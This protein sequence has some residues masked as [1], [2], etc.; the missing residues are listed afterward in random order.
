MNREMPGKKAHY[1]SLAK[2]V[3]ASKVQGERWRCI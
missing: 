3:T 1:K 2:L